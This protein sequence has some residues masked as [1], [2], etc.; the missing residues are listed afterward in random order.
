MACADCTASVPPVCESD[1]TGTISRT[2]GGDGHYLIQTCQNTCTNG[3]CD[4][5]K[6]GVA[7]NA[8]EFSEKCHGELPVY[9]DEDE[10]VTSI[11]GE[12]CHEGSDYI[13]GIDADGYSDCFVPCSMLGEVK[14]YCS[15]NG[16]YNGT[17]VTDTCTDI[18]YHR[19]GYISSYQKCHGPC[20]DGKCMDYSHIPQLGDY[21]DPSTYH[22]ICVSN[23]AL[24]CSNNKITIYEDCSLSKNAR[25]LCGL[26]YD[27]DLNQAA[28]HEPCSKVDT[29]ISQCN[30]EN[31]V[32]YGFVCRDIGYD[33]LGYV[34]ESFD[35]CTCQD[36]VCMQ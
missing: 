30:D 21:C 25:N 23:V 18:G 35:I 24:Y 2:C 10:G 12:S 3:T 17:V 36:G 29:A 11:Y 4:D 27:Q 33:L 32:R 5:T 28:C 7:C 19:L 34:L 15:D 1:I 14:I 9:C 26:T 20:I 8:T 6:L 31:T 13:C 22:E 16:Q